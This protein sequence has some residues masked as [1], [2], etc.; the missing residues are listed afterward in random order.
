[1]PQVRFEPTI[2]A[3]K[4]VKTVHALDH[5]A[6]VIGEAKIKRRKNQKD[7]T[8]DSFETTILLIVFEPAKTRRALD[9]AVKIEKSQPTIYW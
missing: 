4:R 1:M 8:R 6:T 9:C 3:L 5:A 7:I 2:P